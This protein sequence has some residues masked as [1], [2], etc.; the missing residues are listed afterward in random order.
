MKI[1]LV[2]P[3]PKEGPKVIREGRCEQRLSS[4]QYV[5]VPISL[6]SIAGLLEKEG[7]D[8]EIID[9]IVENH[10]FTTAIDA[11]VKKKPDLVITNFSTLTYQSDGVFVKELKKRLPHSHLSAIGVHVTTLPRQ[12]LKDTA[13]DSV[14]RAEPEITVL[15]LAQVLRRGQK[16]NSVQGLSFKNG[17]KIIQNRDRPFI[18]DLDNLPFPARHLLKKDRYLSPV[19]HRP[20]TLLI[21]ARGCPNQC[22]FC[23][24]RKYYGNKFRKRKVSQ[25]IAEI[26]QIVK[27]EKIKEITMWAD[28]FTLDR[29][30]V[31]DLCDEI[32]KRKLKFK[33]LCNSRV[34]TVDKEMLLK[35]KQAGCSGIAFGVESGVQTILNRVKKGITLAQIEKAFALTREVGIESLAHVI[36]GLPGE[37]TQTINQTIAFIKK[38]DPD[39]AQFYCAVPFPGT[40]F[41]SLA[42]K[43]GWIA[44]KD[45][46]RYEIN[47]AIIQTKNLSCR[48]L[49]RARKKAI[50]GFYLRKTFILRQLKQVK[51]LSDL[52]NLINKGAGFLINW[53]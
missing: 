12:T 15:N 13:L 40:E 16:L 34:N 10:N 7:L 52:L 22:I 23:T 17:Q 53:G 47:Q 5:M 31:L 42:Q 26:E 43:E 6:P 18:Q 41:A 32:K 21:T 3:P 11:V 39:Y 20:Y 25:V 1:L 28:T 9:F 19:H 48:Q 33:W 45:W 2:N 37:T 50:Y 27:V 4:F 14:I 38:I 30:F 29:R 24:A 44:T 51:S 46:N 35:M 49:A 8:V 36:F